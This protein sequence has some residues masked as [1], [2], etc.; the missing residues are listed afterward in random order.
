MRASTVKVACIVRTYARSV[1][2]HLT[3]VTGEYQLIEH[4][5]PIDSVGRE[6]EKYTCFQKNNSL[7][8]EFILMF[9]LLYSE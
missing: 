3:G 4:T 7:A 9:K 2:D 8:L 6:E 1:Q 5:L